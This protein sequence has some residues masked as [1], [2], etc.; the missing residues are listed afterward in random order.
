MPSAIVR[1]VSGAL[2]SLPVGPLA[3]VSGPLYLVPRGPPVGIGGKMTAL[4]YFAVILAA[5]AFTA[6]VLAVYLSL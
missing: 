6:L 2:R 1:E 5:L 4:K 3:G